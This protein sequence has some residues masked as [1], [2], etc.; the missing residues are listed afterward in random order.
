MSSDKVLIEWRTD[1][2]WYRRQQKI[3]RKDI[4]P[5][6]TLEIGQKIRVKFNRKS[7]DAVA[8][9]SWK[10]K[11]HGRFFVLNSTLHLFCK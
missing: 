9:E 3:K 2:K 5:E 8:V 1:D 10:P 7:Y 11:S 6:G 4:Q